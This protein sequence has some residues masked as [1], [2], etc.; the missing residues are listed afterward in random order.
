MSNTVSNPF[1]SFVRPDTGKPFGLGLMYIGLPDTD[2][3]SNPVTVKM[4]QADGSDVVISQPINLSAG[5]VATFNGSPVQLKI[6]VDTVSVK[7]ELPSGVPVYYTARWSVPAAGMVSKAELAD[8]NSTV[9][10][11]GVP[12]KE[13]AKSASAIY[14]TVAQMKAAETSQ[15]LIVRCKQYVANGPAVDLVYLS[16]GTSW[17]VVADGYINHTDAG[18]NFLELIA[19]EIGPEMAGAIGDGVVIDKVP[20]QKAADFCA[21]NKRILVI[22]S[23][24]TF[25]L[26]DYILIKNG[27]KGVIGKG[28]TLKYIGPNFSGVMLWGKTNGAAEN[29]SKCVIKDLI[30]DC[31][32]VPGTGVFMNNAS[33][34][35]VEGNQIYGVTNGYGILSRCWINGESDAL[36]NKIS[37]NLI[38]LYQ[39]SSASDPFGQLVFGIALD[40]QIDYSPYPDA[41]AY[42]KANKFDKGANYVN[43]YSDI[44][45]N[46]VLGGY[47]GLQLDSARYCNVQGNQ[48]TR[49]VR[50][51]SAQ[52]RC[53]ANTITG[54]TIV[55]NTS[56][57]IHLAYE[58][59]YNLVE[60]NTIYSSRANQQA[61]L[62]CYVGCVGNKFT[63]NQVTMLGGSNP[64]WHIY[65]GVNSSENE[66]SNNTLRG[67]A[68]KAYIAVESAWNNAV[69]N[70]ASYGFG[71]GPDVNNFA[72]SSTSNNI[73]AENKVYPTAA[74]PCVFLSQVSDAAGN[75][76]LE[77]NVVQNNQIMSNTPLYQLELFEMLSGGISFTKLKD[78]SFDS[79]AT[80]SKFLLPRGQLSFREYE[81]NAVINFNAVDLPPN[82]ATP[83]AS[84]G[85][86]LQHTDSSSTNVTNYINCISGAE[87]IIRLTVNTTLINSSSL[88]RLSGGADISG[89][90]AG[91]T[92]ALVCLRNI[93]GI[94]FEQ[95]RNF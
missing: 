90:S 9:L 75:Y 27:C 36:R 94:W 20:V 60:G 24:F 7:V 79:D 29:V 52:H 6:D 67:P 76:M 64:N 37:N 66:F 42:W 57:G 56:G 63:G 61:L 88:M 39:P 86:L 51:I 17:P 84:V 87:I 15:G 41:P 73:I 50:G 85:K 82:G 19:D 12:A 13:F 43:A 72:S 53:R 83:D 47:Y 23:G 28:G 22:N 44:S 54:N 26:N 35:I 69:T 16:R 74:K 11:A 62:N 71:E 31:N 65:V 68:Q 91:G 93:G 46:T 33:D 38:T 70:P 14:G 58:A 2:P 30:I 45:N 4:V 80:R 59:V 95:W 40:S 92:N 89:A 81:G 78:N 32:G 25:G 8:V 10:I 3:E 21:V 77:R 34:C 49:N 48:T 55:D 1:I 5:G 18:G